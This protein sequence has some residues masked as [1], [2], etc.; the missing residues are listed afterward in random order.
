[1]SGPGRE[2]RKSLVELREVSV[3]GVQWVGVGCE[4]KRGQ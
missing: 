4:S 1:M 2:S 3:V